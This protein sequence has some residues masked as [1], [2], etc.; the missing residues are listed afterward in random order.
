MKTGFAA[1][2]KKEWTE[3]ARSGRLL[4]LLVM[5]LLFGIM[6]PAIAKLTPWLMEQI[7]EQLAEAGLSVSA[8]AVDA[9]TSWAQ[10]Y[11]NIPMAVLLFAVLF[12]GCLSNE[13][14]RKTLIPLLSRGL[15]RRSVIGAKA[16]LI[17]LVWT[18]GYWLCFGVTFAYNAF[19]WG[20]E[21]ASGAFVPALFP[22]LFGLWLISMLFLFSAFARTGTAVLAGL[23]VLLICCF[24]AGML[25]DAARWLPTK[26]LSVQALAAG[27]EETAEFVRASIS[28][29]V[30]GGLGYFVALL[31][32]ERRLL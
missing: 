10:F 27:Q 29:A 11:K 20:S 17:S 25:P 13:C 15:S 3:L 7:A 2:L 1:F 8:V 21:G 24:T 9:K 26:L 31:G 32:F 18:G 6:N 30:S 12:G 16:L 14:E 23:A 19:F 4:I 5:F 28:A 22:W